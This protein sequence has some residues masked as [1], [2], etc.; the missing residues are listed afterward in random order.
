MSQ[1]EFLLWLIAFTMTLVIIIKRNMRFAAALRDVQ[2]IIEES[3]Q[4]MNHHIQVL[5]NSNIGFGNKKQSIE[6]MK[7]EKQRISMVF[8]NVDKYPSQSLRIKRYLKESD[9][10]LEIA[11]NLLKN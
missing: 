7:V 1:N 9:E 11:E 10:Y 2:D 8:R 6:L 3:R 5:E 4:V